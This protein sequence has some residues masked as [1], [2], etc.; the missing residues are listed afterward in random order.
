MH[1]LA[2]LGSLRLWWASDATVRLSFT[3]LW[4]LLRK[5]WWRKGSKWRAH[6]SHSSTCRS[7]RLGWSS[8]LIS[9]TSLTRPS[10]PTCRASG[11][12]PINVVLL[13]C[14]DPSFSTSAP[15]A[16]QS[17]SSW[18]WGHRWGDFYGPLPGVSQSHPLHGGRGEVLLVL[19][20]KAL[21]LRVPLQAA[22]G[23]TVGPHQ[24]EGCQHH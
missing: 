20:T 12:S 6:M 13:G 17:L 11:K 14:W 18:Q 24:G 1:L 16:S 2:Q 10:Y 5:R 23:G 3:L 9:L 19:G 8:A 21:L 15:S 22:T 7:C 4:R